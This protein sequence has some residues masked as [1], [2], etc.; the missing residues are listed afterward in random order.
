MVNH[1]ED[2]G[3]LSGSGFTS[4]ITEHRGASHRRDLKV[5]GGQRSYFQ[6]LFA[7]HMLGASP[8][9]W[10]DQNCWNDE[11][12]GVDWRQEEEKSTGKERWARVSP[13]PARCPLNRLHTGSADHRLWRNSSLGRWDRTPGAS[14]GRRGPALTTRRGWGLGSG[15]GIFP[16]LSHIPWW[17]WFSC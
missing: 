17:W 9:H 10:W 15:G 5:E 6:D 7:S 16:F 4:W 8:P 3:S 12:S 2:Y 13:F 14:A 1:L 11:G